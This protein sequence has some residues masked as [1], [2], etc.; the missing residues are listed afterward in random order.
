M[1]PFTDRHHRRSI[2]LKGY[3]YTQAGAY[4]ITIVTHQRQCF[5]GEIVNA[6]MKP[7]DLGQTALNCWL[8]ISEHHPHADLDEFV[9]MPNHIHG[10]IVITDNARRGVPGKGVQ[11][12]APTPPPASDAP[13][14]TTKIPK[15]RD[16]TNPFSVLS[17]HQKSLGVIVRTYKAAV[18][19]ACRAMQRYDFGW[20]KNYYDH[21]IRNDRDLNRIREYIFN[22][23]FN[24]HTDTENP[25]HS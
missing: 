10:I 22:N 6:E 7:S 19:T 5:F 11:L 23:P 24:W 12:N 20:Q 17:P 4:Y 16:A 1:N 3:D 9:I 25:N 15:P 21:I 14:H 8:A 13:G 2:R 18:T